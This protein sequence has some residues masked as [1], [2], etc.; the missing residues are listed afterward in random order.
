MTQ[1]ATQ[2]V[3]SRYRSGIYERLPPK[4]THMAEQ[5]TT[6]R[7]DRIQVGDALYQRSAD[8]AWTVTAIKE[9]NSFGDLAV[10][11]APHGH[12]YRVLDPNEQIEVIV[13]A[14]H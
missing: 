14:N 1:A 6:I 5:L 10:Y 8:A 3:C 2:Y 12:V 9:A 4:G 11:T 7:A 13:G